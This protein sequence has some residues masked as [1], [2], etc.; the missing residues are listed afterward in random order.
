MASRKYNCKDVDMLVTSNVVMESFNNHKKVLVGKRK[1]WAEPFAADLQQKIGN[2]LDIILGANT[3]IE[4]TSTTRQLVTI[5][6]QTVEDLVTFKIQLEVDFD[7]DPDTLKIIE[8]RL[9][10]TRLYDQVYAGGQEALIQ[11]LTVF[12]RNMKPELRQQIEDA[13]MDGASIDEL[14]N[15]RDPIHETNIRQ[16]VL[17][18]STPKDTNLN[19][20]EMNVIYKLVIGICRIAPR[21]LPDVPT[22]K[23][24]FSF[25]RILSRLH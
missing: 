1:T 5:Q 8:D 15:M 18:G 11:L 12:K 24:D 2:A 19:V 22:A 3:K 14:I 10:F 25:A 13:G 20:D 4:Q 17:K 9:G 6:Y 16:E 7:D 23:E 21:L